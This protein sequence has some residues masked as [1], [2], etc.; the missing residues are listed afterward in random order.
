M[1]YME[2]PL[3]NPND[4]LSAHCPQRRSSNGSM[5][6][7]SGSGSSNDDGRGGGSGGHW[8]QLKIWCGMVDAPLPGCRS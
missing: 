6:G 7:S 1:T 4:P 5:D 2:E 3:R 8:S